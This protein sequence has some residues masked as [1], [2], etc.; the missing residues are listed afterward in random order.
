[1]RVAYVTTDPGIPA[2]GVKG[3][4]IHVQSILAA[5]LARGAEVTL[6]APAPGPVP[7]ALEGLR[8]EPL[9]ATPKGAAEARAD[10]LL[11]ADA[12]L[13]GRLAAAGPFDLVYERHALFAAGATAFA[14]AQGIPSILEVNA[15]LLEEQAR[16]RGLARP[17]EAQAATR[18]A[19]QAATRVVAVSP[20]VADY[21]RA[22]GA[23]APIVVPNG[24]DPARFAARAPFAGPF[25]VGFVGTLKPWHD[26]ATLLAALPLLRDE[27]PEARLLIVGD[28]PERERL[29]GQA[30]ADGVADAVEFTG[31]LSPER[32]PGQL[33]RMHVGVA[34]YRGG[35]PFYF[36]PLKLYEYMAAGLP[37]VVSDVGDL[38]GIVAEAGAGVA[39]APDDP[40]ALAQALADLARA[41]GQA[42]R[43]G[44]AGRAHVI[45][46]HGW[47]R[48]LERTLDGLAPAPVRGAA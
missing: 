26:T 30:D 48:V 16:H 4:S 28:G 44:A 27:V 32:V 41:P 33:A 11:A 14:T 20:G 38:G 6:F 36:S 37:V 12:A 13:P 40:A 5:F 31:A 2:F 25:T 43:L 8:V 45:A 21:A 35:A 9:P 22:H 23:A 3:A 29:A 10:A 24:V 19:M 47:D 1:M 15:P 46:H 18:A 42:A 34:P 39:V 17:R 7:E